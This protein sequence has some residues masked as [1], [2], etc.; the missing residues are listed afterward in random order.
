[1]CVCVCVCV[2]VVGSGMRGGEETCMWIFGYE[3]LKEIDC[4]EDLGHR[5]KDNIKKHLKASNERMVFELEEEMRNK[6]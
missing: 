1:M 5:W 4:L 3:G 2:S 6:W